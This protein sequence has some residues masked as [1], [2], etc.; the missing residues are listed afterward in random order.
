MRCERGTSAIEFAVVSGLFFTLVFG[1]I[2]Y[3]SYLGAQAALNHI[4]YESARASIAGLD[5]DER[6]AL[7]TTR[8]NALVTSFSG[9][10]NEESVDIRIDNTS[11]PGVFSVT[12]SQDFDALGLSGTIL[13]LPMPNAAQSATAE[14]SYG[15]Y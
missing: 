10:L 9:I 4:A 1:I 12:V 7:A 8:A 15:G 6:T 2:V 11:T 3:G 13:F 5:S 14:V